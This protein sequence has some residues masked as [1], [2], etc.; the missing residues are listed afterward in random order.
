[1]CSFFLCAH[2]LLLFSPPCFGVP[3]KPTK[4]SSFKSGRGGAPLASCP[5]LS[6]ALDY[7]SLT[8]AAIAELMPEGLL[9]ETLAC[10]TAA[11]S[12]APSGGG[13]T[14][15]ERDLR[16]LVLENAR[17]MNAT[18]APPRAA[19]SR[20]LLHA[21]DPKPPWPSLHAPLPPPPA[22][23]KAIYWGDGALTSAQCADMVALFEGSGSLFEGNVMYGGN[24][25]VDKKSKNR[26]EFDVSGFVEGAA[27]DGTIDRGD[28]PAWAA[29]DRA[30]VA[31]TVR[32]LRLYERANP[33]VTTLRSPFG[34]EGFRMI[35]YDAEAE[36]EELHDWHVDGGQEPQGTP[37]RVLAVIIYLSEPEEGGETLFLN[38][39][40]A[41]APKCG[42]VLIFPSAFPYIHAGRPVL[43]GKKYALTLMVTL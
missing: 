3:K 30:A 12:Q 28:A 26:W 34:D 43:A 18:L 20:R 1:M 24:V 29:V 41:V 15:R 23:D 17:V 7:V 36:E 33:M 35:R 40:I 32:H 10:F 39:G 21:L 16:D 31:A 19:F 9:E 5:L 42:R 14:E 11:L 6:R 37:A 22:A 2:L 25:L 38:Q 8:N 27:R 4:Q 13:L